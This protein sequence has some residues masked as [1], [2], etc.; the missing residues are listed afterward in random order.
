MTQ[1]ICLARKGLFVYVIMHATM[2]T[3]ASACSY[4]RTVPLRR[5]SAVAVA[6]Q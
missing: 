3:Y 1:W 4:C 6:S 5:S 2:Q